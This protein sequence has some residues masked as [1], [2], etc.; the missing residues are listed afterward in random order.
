MNSKE[1]GHSPKRAVLYAR[2][3]TDEQAKR[4]YSIP[5][6]LKELRREAQHRDYHVIEEIIDDG[7]SG[8]TLERP[9][10]KR[11]IELAEAGACD[12]VLASKRDRYFR[13]RLKRLLMDEDFKEYGVSLAALNDTGNKIGDGVQDDFAEWER[14]QITERTKRGKLGRARAGKVIPSGSPP[15][16]FTYDGETLKVD[17]A[18]MPI[19]RRIFRDIGERGMGLHEVK[20]SLE[21]DSVS[22]ANGAAFWHTNTLKRIVFHDAYK[23]HTLEELAEMISEDVASRLDPEKSYGVLWYNRYASVTTA[24]GTRLKGSMNSREKWIAVPVEDAGVPSAVVEAARERVEDKRRPSRADNRFWS[25][26]GHAYCPCGR[27]LACR[28]AMPRGERY[29]YYVCSCY[30]KESSRG[31]EYGKRH[32]AEEL[33]GRIFWAV[34]EMVRDPESL[35]KM[36]GRY[37]EEESPRLKGSRQGPRERLRCTQGRS[38]TEGSLSGDGLPRP[39]HLRGAGRSLEG[40]R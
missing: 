33:E 22:T 26:S 12:V 20:R 25:L 2:V 39:D 14:E 36:I 35:R 40:P 18:K 19:V 31:C 11:V 13:S 27:L 21:R 15:L 3:S 8:A 34:W 38:G 7:Y 29:Y 10:L 37:I 24:K 9:G 23:P 5:D 6:Q 30:D 28:S 17:E 1:N 16:G 4:G 32:R